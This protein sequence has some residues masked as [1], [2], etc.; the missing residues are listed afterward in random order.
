MPNATADYRTCAG[1]ESKVEKILYPYPGPELCLQTSQELEGSDATYTTAIDFH[2]PHPGGRR[3]EVYRQIGVSLTD[4][5]SSYNVARL[6][7]DPG[8][9]IPSHA[10]VAQAVF[11]TEDMLRRIGKTRD[12]DVGGR[13]HLT[14]VAVPQLLE[15]LFVLPQS[16]VVFPVRLES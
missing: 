8:F 13:H 5:T 4:R 1:P 15:V 7:A 10:R 11:A 3:L 12:A 2:H 6:L 16:P 9:P 14:C